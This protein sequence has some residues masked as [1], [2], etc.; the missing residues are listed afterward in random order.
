MQKKAEEATS[1]EGKEDIRWMN[2]HWINRIV[3]G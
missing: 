1:M 2:I 3:L